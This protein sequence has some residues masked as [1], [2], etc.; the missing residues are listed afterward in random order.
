MRGYLKL[1]IAKV[2]GNLAHASSSVTL[3]SWEGPGD[4]SA[5]NWRSY[6]KT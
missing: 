2:P 1:G 4:F 3:K 5:K 6:T